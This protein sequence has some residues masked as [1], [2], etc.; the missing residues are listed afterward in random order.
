MHS[1]LTNNIF[2]LESISLFEQRNFKLMKKLM[3]HAMKCIIGKHFAA[4]ITNF[5]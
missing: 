2:M 3:Q 4:K 1:N 5:I